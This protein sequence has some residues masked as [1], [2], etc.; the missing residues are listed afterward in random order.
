MHLKAYILTLLP[1][2]LISASFAEH[3]KQT[4]GD[5]IVLLESR[6]A[7]DESKLLGSAL[8]VVRE[9]L[10]E[11]ETVIPQQSLRELKQV[12]IWV[13]YNSGRG[14]CYHPS[15]KWLENNDRNPE[16]ARSIEIVNA[17][18]FVSWIDHQPMML[19]HELAHA[20]HHRKLGFKDDAITDAY[21]NAVAKGLYRKVPYWNKAEKDAYALT[22]EK[23]YFAEL[24]EAY[25]GKND[26]FP[27]NVEELAAYDPVG[28]EM[29]KT[30]W[31]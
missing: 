23:E 21:Q 10:E 16:M 9:K 11:I 28:Y 19:L 5:W 24:T 22:N 1:L 26:I 30:I 3:T 7:P 20:L 18:D 25:W 12:P 4:V 14:A 17:K 6:T 8:E 15:K 27:F 2:A 13:S 31:K 29:I